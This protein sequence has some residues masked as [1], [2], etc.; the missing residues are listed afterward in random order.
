MRCLKKIGFIALGMLGF[1]ALLCS[2]AASG[3]VN[4][5]WMEQGFLS[6]SDTAHLSVPPTQYTHYAKAISAYLVGKA[7]SVSVPSLADENL[8]QLAFSEKENLHL[9]DVRGIVSV[10]KS[11]RWIGGGLVIA[12]IAGL[13]LFSPQEKKS[14]LLTKILE[15]FAWGA[16]AL[17]SLAASLCIWGAVNFD[18][19]FWFFHQVA[20]ANDLWLLN[21]QTDLLMA[22]MPLDFFIWYA[23]ELL[24]SLLPVLGMMLLL[25]IAW[26]KVGKKEAQ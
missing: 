26:F 17:L 22:L 10:L 18:G 12:V 13:Y 5:H 8:S 19:L 16:I 3:V 1:L 7:E 11:M 9:A 15:G 20:F 2:I 25:I 21:P 23:K 4:A 14:A 24:K 6:Y